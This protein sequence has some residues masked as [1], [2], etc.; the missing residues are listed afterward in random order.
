MDLRRD[1][2]VRVGSGKVCP[3]IRMNNGLDGRRASWL[4]GRGRHEQIPQVESEMVKVSSS[5]SSIAA[6][7]TFSASSIELSSTY[8]HRPKRPPLLTATHHWSRQVAAF[9][10]V[11]PGLLRPPE[12]SMIK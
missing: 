12:T 8:A 4:L 6:P 3:F 5:S 1:E 7:S 10:A 9:T 2:V 11:G